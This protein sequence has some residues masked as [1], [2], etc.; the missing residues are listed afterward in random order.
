MISK[1]LPKDL[2]PSPFFAELDRL[3]ALGEFLDLT[4]S[5]PLKAGISPD[6]EGAVGASFNFWGRWEPNP[7]GSLLARR[8]V[9]GYYSDRGGSFEEGDFI[10]T[11]STSEAYSFLF[12]A[13]SDPGDV[14]LTPMPGYPLLDALA[15]LEH[16]RCHPYFLKLRS[17]RFELDLASLLSAP[18]RAKILL[19]VS[20]HNPT[21]HS[22]S[23]E[24]WEGVCA[25]CSERRLVLVVDEVF[26]DYRAEGTFERTWKFPRPG[27]VPIFWLNGLSKTVGSPELKL[28]W[29]ACSLPEASRAGM[30]DA[31]EY[32]ADAYLGVSAPAEA[33]AVPLLKTSLAFEERVNARIRGNLALLRE[34]F[35]LEACPKI[36]G[37][38]YAALHLEVDDEAF[39]L[40]L[41][42]AWR[43]L[44]QPGFFF[45]FDG[46]GWLVLSLLAEPAIF[47][48][49]LRRLSR[50]AERLG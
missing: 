2:A 29:M 21:G 32:V 17:G 1:R 4:V 28:G 5:S 41:L 27:D 50:A 30:L 48:E 7:R 11:A 16:L 34:R 6:L 49:G 26:G 36:V 24:E 45:D 37:G 47:A 3:K 33:L 35:P 20:P 13:F 43:V 9:A 15:S 38:W 10:L 19:L 18:E 42:E 46:D 12:K 25:F 39:T 22:V 14:V 40:R 44:V 8:A 23:L 31:L